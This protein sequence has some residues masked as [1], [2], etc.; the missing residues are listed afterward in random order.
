MSEQRQSPRTEINHE[1]KSIA[2]FLHEYALNVSSGGVFIRT[3]DVVPVGTRVALRFSV[4]AQDIETIEGEGRV[5]RA[6]EPA[7]S[8]TPGMG[9]VFTE[10]TEES[11]K[12]LASLFVHHADR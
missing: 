6:V 12:V 2:E 11:R 9:V 5:V 1:F 7:D 4:I 8:D 10:L 3:T